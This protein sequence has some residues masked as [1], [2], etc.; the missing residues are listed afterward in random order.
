MLHTISPEKRNGPNTVND[1]IRQSRLLNEQY[2]IVD[3]EQKILPQKNPFKI[4][5]LIFELKKEIQKAQPDLVLVCGLQFAGF[6][7]TVAAKLKQVKKIVVCVHGFSGDA[8]NLSR[9][10]RFLFNHL[11]E[12]LTIK[13]ADSVYTVCDF[14]SNRPMIR[15]YAKGKFF[16]TIHNCLP[17]P[18]TEIHDGFRKEFGISEDMCVVVSIGR[19]VIDKG[20][21]EII[22]ALHT[23]FPQNVVLV[24]VGDGP[25]TD[26]YRAECKEQIVNGKLILTGSRKDVLSILNESDIFL[27]PTYHENLSMALLEACFMRCAVIATDVDGNPEII[28]NKEN[29]LLIEPRNS[30]QILQ[31]INVLVQDEDLRRKYANKAY[32]TV[33]TEFS[34]SLF[35]ERLFHLF[36]TMMQEID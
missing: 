17:P 16:G 2:D 15:K 34:Y 7:A 36:N 3:L 9:I 30:K 32:D 20:H 23:G 14:A 8:V 4:C 25:Y 12:P 1:C 5:K 35:E 18:S 27:F 21:Q 11:I 10:M 28:H 19:V 13:M 22:Q 33:I 31:A 24:I 29:G 6:C 26:F